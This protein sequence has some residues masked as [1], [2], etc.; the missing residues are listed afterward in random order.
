MNEK[1]VQGIVFA[2]IVIV[3][4]GLYHNQYHKYTLLTSSR[5]TERKRKMK[6]IVI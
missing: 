5:E 2:L 4:V 1:K 3:V 6:S